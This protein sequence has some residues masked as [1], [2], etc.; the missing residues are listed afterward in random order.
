MVTYDLTPLSADVAEIPSIEWNYF[1]TTPGVE[2]FVEVATS[3][4]PVTIDAIANAETIASLPEAAKAAVTPGVDDI[5]DL[6]SFDGP[7]AVAAQPPLWQMWSAV[8]SPWG[9]VLAVFADLGVLVGLA[10]LVDLTPDLLVKVLPGDL[11]VVCPHFVTTPGCWF[12]GPVQ[13]PN[14]FKGFSCFVKDF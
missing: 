8:L 13:Y 14:R 12:P 7:V 1:D 5:F 3:P 9:F 10:V 11:A 2:A 4:L 6:P